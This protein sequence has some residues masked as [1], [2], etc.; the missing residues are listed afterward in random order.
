[1]VHGDIVFVL[2]P[3]DIGVDRNGGRV[4]ARLAPARFLHF[5]RRMGSVYNPE[6]NVDLSDLT[7]SYCNV[8]LEGILGGT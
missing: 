6:Y 2:Y 8:D 3:C 5:L 7:L 1:M 4:G